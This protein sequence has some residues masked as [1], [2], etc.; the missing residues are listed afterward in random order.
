MAELDRSQA[1]SEL[2]ELLAEVCYY[3]T[4]GDLKRLERP[5]WSGYYTKVLEYD[6]KFPGIKKAFDCGLK[7][8]VPAICLDGY[9][10]EEEPPGRR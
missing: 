5:L 2:A 9:L 4:L 1:E 6:Q 7:K 8:V 3:S 10:F